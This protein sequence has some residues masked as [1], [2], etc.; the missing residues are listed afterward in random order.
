MKFVCDSCSA[1][2]QIPDKKIEGRTLRMKCRKCGHAIIIKGPVP[3]AAKQDSPAIARRASPSTAGARRPARKSALG[4]D[5][6]RGGSTAPPSGK[7][8]APKWHVS[9]NDVPVGP[10]KRE[11][12]ARKIGTGSV[13]EGSLVWREGFDDWRPLKQVPE[14]L[15]LLRQR[16][17]PPPPT[18]EGSKSNVVPI[19]GKLE[20]PGFIDEFDD[21]RTV[22]APLPKAPAAVAGMG[23]SGA[24]PAAVAA[25]QPELDL[26]F[27]EPEVAAALAPAPI[28]QPDA[29]QGIA[30]A[31]AFEPAPAAVP[32]EPATAEEEKRRI[33]LGFW[34]AAI[35]VMVFAVTLGVMVAARYLMPPDPVAAQG[36]VR[37]NEN[38]APVAPAQEELEVPAEVEE[39]VEAPPEEGP[40]EPEAETPE[41]NPAA[42]S[43]EM[44]PRR[45]SRGGST[46]MRPAAAEE[47]PS[48][49]DNLTAEQRRQLALL[50]MGGGSS[51]GPSNIRR[52]SGSSM[53][54]E[55]L[56]GAAVRRVVTA[57]SNTQ[58]LQRCYERAIR[59][60]GNPPSV[61]LDVRINVGASGRVTNVTVGG[62]DFGGLKNCVTTS[63]R[64]WVFPRSSNG[65]PA[66]FPVVFAA[67]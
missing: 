19:G 28:P 39:V 41:E 4:S 8:A 46:G 25:A 15:S 24:A 54:G 35:G 50:Q 21:E 12:L 67:P 48:G 29:L 11:E 23:G 33:P 10:I 16:R 62:N 1:K 30:P 45:P 61:R 63:V 2:Y 38:L 26:N 49:G 22:M 31:P 13:N 56:D 32:L 55:P 20:S 34:L 60:Q 14:L 53:S 59:G 58:A 43:S 66:R 17:M 47:E 64:R 57:R 9:I 3:G 36:E 18:P 40:E 52:G 44:R 27:G 37:V 51:M 42:S 5:F 65:G 6:R 7:P